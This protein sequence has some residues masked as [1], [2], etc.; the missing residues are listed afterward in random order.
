MSDY[1]FSENST[2]IPVKKDINYIIKGRERAVRLEIRS[3]NV[4]AGRA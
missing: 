3:R 2:E 4:H 1:C